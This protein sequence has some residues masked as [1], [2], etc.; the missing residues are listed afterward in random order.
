MDDIR[1]IGRVARRRWRS[2][3]SALRR[4]PMRI[5][6]MIVHTDNRAKVDCVRRWLRST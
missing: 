6:D 3:D 5:F 1:R 4:V 2:P